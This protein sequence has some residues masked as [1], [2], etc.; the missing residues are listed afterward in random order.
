VLG[1]TAVSADRLQFPAVLALPDELEQTGP[2]ISVPDSAGVWKAIYPLVA[3][4]TGRL[5]LPVVRIPVVSATAERSLAVRPPVL[6]VISVLPPADQ[7]PRLQP[8]RMPSERWRI[9]WRW[10]LFFLLL[11]A[12][13]REAWRRMRS[14]PQPVQNLEETSVDPFGEARDALL[15]LRA[16]AVSGEA[17]TDRFYD[18]IE[19]AVRLYLVRTRGWPEQAPVRNALNGGLAGEVDRLDRVVRRALPARFGALE[20]RNDT[21]VSDVDVVLAWLDSEQAA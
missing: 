10:L 15:A 8:P 21:L 4:K 16:R 5:E 6:E 7:G 11:A 19:K 14:A 1:I 12:L 13:A 3:W 9:P 20:V 2:P 17:R 18:G